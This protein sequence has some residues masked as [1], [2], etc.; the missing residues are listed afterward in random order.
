MSIRWLIRKAP[1]LALLAAMPVPAKAVTFPQMVMGSGFEVVLIVTNKTSSPWS[2]T[3]YLRS[4]NEAGWPTTWRLDGSLQGGSS[5][6]VNLSAN[7]TRSYRLTSDA[8]AVGYLRIE[9][10]GLSMDRDLSVSF[11]FEFIDDN[12]LEDST[13]VSADP[14]VNSVRFPVERAFNGGVNTGFALAPSTTNQFGPVLSAFTIR[15]SLFNQQG[16]R[17][18]VV[19]RQYQGQQAEFFGETFNIGSDFVGSMQIDSDEAVHVTVLRQDLTGPAP[20]LTTIPASDLL[21]IE[22]SAFNRGERIPA[23]HTC[24]G[25]DISPPLFWS[26]PPPGTVSQVLIVSEVNDRDAISLFQWIIYDLPP[27]VR[28]LGQDQPIEQDILDNGG[29]QGLN[30]LG[31]IGYSGPKPLPGQGEVRYVFRLYALD[32]NLI[33]LPLGATGPEVLQAIQGRVLAIAEFW[34]TDQF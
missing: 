33:Q 13:G 25:S 5:F 24:D 16:A 9:G 17:V 11:F 34:G 26:E 12:R 15:L 29:V 2:G 31:R 1:L 32:T 30:D 14:P 7:A 23:R 21:R 27:D 19:T 3:V 10:N 4:G 20:Q 6:N 28:H 18:Q 22:S 8:L